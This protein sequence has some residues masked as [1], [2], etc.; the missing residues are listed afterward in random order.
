MIRLVG[1]GL[2]K[3]Y[4]EKGKPLSK[5]ISKKKAVARLGQ[6]EYFKHHKGAKS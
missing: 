2:Y 5:A 4:S 3:V 1:G 6:I